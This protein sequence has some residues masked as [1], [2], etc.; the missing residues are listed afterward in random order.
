MTKVFK[1]IDKGKIIVIIKKIEGWYLAGLDDDSLKKLHINFKGNT[2]NVDK[3]IFANAMP[4]SFTSE[5]DFLQ[6]ILKNYS[7]DTAITKNQ[8]FKYFYHKY[9]T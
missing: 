5:K 6:E 3:Q 2:D 1:E 4:K 9:L 7:S 8:S